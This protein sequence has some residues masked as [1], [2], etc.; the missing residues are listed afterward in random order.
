MKKRKNRANE[1]QKDKISSGFLLENREN[2]NHL[3][4]KSKNK[5]D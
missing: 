4:K 3:C 1:L 5:G 2:Q